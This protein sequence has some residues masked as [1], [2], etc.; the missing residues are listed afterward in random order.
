MG[1]TE[2][3]AT[4]IT[5]TIESAVIAKQCLRT[6]L[7]RADWR[8]DVDDFLLLPVGDVVVQVTVIWHG[9]RALAKSGKLESSTP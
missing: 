1:F 2:V 7:T 3:G 8:H 9:C 5:V 6:N 4:A